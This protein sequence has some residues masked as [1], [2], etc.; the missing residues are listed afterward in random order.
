MY[1]VNSIKE[2]NNTVYI[3]SSPPL[4]TLW[5]VLLLPMQK[6]LHYCTEK[7]NFSVHCNAEDSHFEV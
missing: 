2:D 1:K 4:F 5:N 7:D 6:S 3:L